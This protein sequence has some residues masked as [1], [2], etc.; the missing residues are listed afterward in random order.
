[1]TSAN[2]MYPVG[3]TSSFPSIGD[4]RRTQPDLANANGGPS[5][6][7]LLN[8]TNQRKMAINDEVR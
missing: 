6:V 2:A 3:K 4:D 5:F 7:Q 8:E 1:M